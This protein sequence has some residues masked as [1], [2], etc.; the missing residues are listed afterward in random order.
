VA[1]MK[2][3]LEKEN[4]LKLQA[5]FLA[6]LA[7]SVLTCCHLSVRQKCTKFWIDWQFREDRQSHIGQLE[8]Q[9]KSSF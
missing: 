5:D 7:R 6:L 9:N 1:Q 2:N 3:H 4:H 8:C